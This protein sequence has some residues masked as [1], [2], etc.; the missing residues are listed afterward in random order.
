MRFNVRFIHNIQPVYV[1]QGQEIRVGRVVRRAH[2]VY[3]Q[4]LHELYIPFEIRVAHHVSVMKGRVVMVDAL[5]FD[6]LPV[7]IEDGVLDLDRLEA[8]HGA[9]GHFFRFFTEKRQIQRV[10]DGQLGVPFGDVKILETDANA[11]LCGNGRVGNDLSVFVQKLCRKPSALGFPLYPGVHL[12][13]VGFVRFFGQSLK[14]IHIGPA[15]M[16]K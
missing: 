4:A 8:C 5:H 15:V 12:Q 6:G 7:E 14:V 1:A 11:L 2:R 16:V 10:G 3:V 13:G 9:Q